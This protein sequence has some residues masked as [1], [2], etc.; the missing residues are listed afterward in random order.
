MNM[1]NSK[2]QHNIQIPLD[3]P[4]V[5]IKSVEINERKD[6]L[7]SIESRR[8]SAI[9]QHCGKEIRKSRGT[10][11]EITLR[12]LSVFGHRVYIR[13]RPKRFECPDCGGRTTTQKLSWY[14]AKS[15]HTKAYDQYLILLLVNT[16]NSVKLLS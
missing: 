11:H 10:G 13:L 2:S 3:I 7:I 12:H 9:C 1:M 15:P 14:E 8:E 16:E 6:Y 5:T 4:E